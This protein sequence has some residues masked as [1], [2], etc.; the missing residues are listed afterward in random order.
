MTKVPWGWGQYSAQAKT[1]SSHS[2]PHFH[3]G[4]GGG[5]G[6][7]ILPNLKRKVI[8][9]DKSFISGYSA[10]AKTQS[11]IGGGGSLKKS[12]SDIL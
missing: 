6:A 4:G 12:L 1:Q 11:F 10:Q 8:S 5:E 3:W 2:L 9:P 7:G